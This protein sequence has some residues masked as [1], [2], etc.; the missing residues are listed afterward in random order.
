MKNNNELS[1][2][3][4]AY[5]EEKVIDECLKA[6]FKIKKLKLNVIVIDDGSTDKTSNIASKYPCKLIKNKKNIGAALSK[7][8]AIKSAKFKYI[9]IIDA[10]SIVRE[11]AIEKMFFYLKSK[12]NLSGINGMW[13]YKTPS[14]SFF[15]KVQALDTNFQMRIMK[16]EKFSFY[17]GN[18]SIIK[19]KIFL[20]SGGFS[21]YYK[22]AGCEDY[23]I[24]FRMN[25]NKK[26]L[27]PGIV[28]INHHFPSF[29]FNGFLKYIFRTALF[30]QTYLFYKNR[31]NSGDNW[32]T[33][34]K[35]LYSLL[36]VCL[37]L[38]GFLGGFFINTLIYIF[39]FLG[40]FSLILN[41]FK[42]IKFIRKKTSIY[43]V[44]LYIPTSI[45]MY[46]LIGVGIVFGIIRFLVSKN[47]F[48]K[49]N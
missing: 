18:G 23:E 14:K 1:I 48:T 37:M 45:I 35:N 28:S 13:N 7:N 27:V 34:N 11:G 10:N 32:H 22:K 29:F 8:K 24:I 3:I 44:F 47:E 6:V 39:L 49:Y 33:T 21:S 17:W 41:N 4:P 26:F 19:K 42:K 15:S 9:L 20:K 43:F 31:V 16:K 25:N 12:K 30:I 5:N 40:L 46:L 2:I 38:V 36:S